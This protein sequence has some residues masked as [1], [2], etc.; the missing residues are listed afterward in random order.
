MVS[1]NYG[2][3]DHHS[4]IKGAFESQAPQFDVAFARL[5]KD[6][7]E[8]GMLDTTLVLVS[9]EFGRTPR[10]NS[11]NG[12][13]HYPRVFSVAMA[14]GGVKKGFVYGKS[15]ALGGEPDENPVGPED[16]ARTMYRL[17]GINASKRIVVENVR[18]VDIVN[19][20]RLLQEVIA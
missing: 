18:P 13:D 8:R 2:G 15:D 14:G 20:G 11:T 1:V 3:W 6:L 19:G 17:L 9:S 10:I 4:N 7:D 12:R 16:L 5:I